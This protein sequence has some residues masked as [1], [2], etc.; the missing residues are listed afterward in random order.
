MESS[1]QEVLITEEQIQKK[2]AELGE[3]LTKE[4]EGKERNNAV[5]LGRRGPC[6]CG[7]WSFG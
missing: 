3:I 1:I 7:Y 6:G 4:Y 5:L 2:V